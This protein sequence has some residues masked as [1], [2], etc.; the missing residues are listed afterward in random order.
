MFKNPLRDM[1][2]NSGVEGA[3]RSAN[4]PCSAR[5]IEGVY[6]VVSI[7]RRDAV[8]HTVGRQSLGAVERNGLNIGVSCLDC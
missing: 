8:L 4:V 7:G 5:A 3:C 6:Y 2:P 1:F